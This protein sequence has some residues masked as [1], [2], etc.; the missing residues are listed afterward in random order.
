MTDA[1]RLSADLLRYHLQSYLDWAKYDD[2][3]FPLDQFNGANIWLPNALTVQHPIRTA[4]DVSNYV[5]RLGQ[6][7]PRMA[8]AV[9]EA[10][11][12]AAKDLIPPRFILNL[13]IDQMRRFVSTPAAQN[14]FVTSL[15]ERAATIKELAP[16]D[17][18]AA[19]AQAERIVRERVYPEWKTAI[20]Y[21]ESLVPR[22]AERAGPVAPRRGRRGV[23]IF[24]QE[25]HDDR[26]HARSNP[27]DRPS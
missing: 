27:R 5:A 13:T 6:V 18:A 15:D 22:S 21:L 14:P 17:R 1:Q 26:S 12:R 8:E 10:R 2:Y 19:V 3:V 23:C 7:A 25:L 24:P 20:A 11:Q 16:A 9:V 4:K